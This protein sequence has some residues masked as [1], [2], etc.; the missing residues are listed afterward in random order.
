MRP[1]PQKD[2]TSSEGSLA[3]RVLSGGL[4]RAGGPRPRRARAGAVFKLPSLK[5]LSF[6]DSLNISSCHCFGRWFRV[7]VRGGT[8]L[9]GTAGVRAGPGET[10]GGAATRSDRRRLV[11][12][13]GCLSRAGEFHQFHD[14]DP[15]MSRTIMTGGRRRVRN[16]FPSA[17][18]QLNPFATIVKVST[19][20]VAR[21]DQRHVPRCFNQDVTSNLEQYIFP[22]V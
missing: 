1:G 6:S 20:N 7:K 9:G 11:P 12:G 15:A 2:Q 22:T 4:A 8:G 21:A 10:R 14:H 19:G 13:H 3:V 16:P 18:W 17:S 5:V